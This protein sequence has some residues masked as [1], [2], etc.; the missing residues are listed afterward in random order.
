MRGTEQI[1]INT[2]NHMIYPLFFFREVNAKPIA[3]K[4]TKITLPAPITI[5][6]GNSPFNIPPKIKLANVNFDKSI[7]NLPRLSHNSGFGCIFLFPMPTIYH[8]WGLWARV[9]GALE[10]ARG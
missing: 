1:V 6:C 3:A 8:I 9:I 4:T 2:T 10:S 7:N 5:V